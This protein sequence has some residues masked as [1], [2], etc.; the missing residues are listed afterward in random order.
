MV[1]KGQSADLL[2]IGVYTPREAA[3]YARV[4][5]QTMQR[6]LWGGL[7]SESAFTPE[8]DGP[9]LVSFRDFVTTLAIRSIRNSQQPVSLQK[10]RS[11][12]QLKV[13][14]MLEFYFIGSEIE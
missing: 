8:I 10:I 4:P 7:N 11:A 6:W 12:I 1:A 5:T 3:F 2:G 9:K 13:A 14:N